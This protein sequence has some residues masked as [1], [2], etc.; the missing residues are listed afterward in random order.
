MQW[1]KKLLASLHIHILM[2]YSNSLLSSVFQRVNDLPITGEIDE[3]TLETMRQPRCGLEDPFNK[4]SNKYRVLGK[5]CM[6]E[7]DRDLSCCLEMY[8]I[9][10]LQ[11]SI[12][13]LLS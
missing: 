13:F 6:A 11:L 12:L 3:A 7:N 2:I 1:M 4:I 5:L 8:E 9:K 10:F